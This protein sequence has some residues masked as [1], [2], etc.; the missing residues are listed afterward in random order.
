MGEEANRPY[1]QL[2]KQQRCQL[3]MELAGM[4]EESDAARMSAAMVLPVLAPKLGF[5]ITQSNLEDAAEA[6]GVKLHRRLMNRAPTAEVLQEISGRVEV[7]ESALSEIA[8]AHR[9]RLSLVE[10]KVNH[11]AALTAA[12]RDGQSVLE[13]RLSEL[14]GAVLRLEQILEGL[15]APS[16]APAAGECFTVPNVRR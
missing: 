11:L 9:E 13:T 3:W 16:A 6:T 5:R 8:P 10:G 7:L 12:Q 15:T 14:R 2:T 4:K 1:N